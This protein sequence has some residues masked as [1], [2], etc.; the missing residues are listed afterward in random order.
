MI[1][2]ELSDFS[3]ASRIFDNVTEL[4]LIS[5]KDT[6][7]GHNSVTIARGHNINIIINSWER[8]TK[9]MAD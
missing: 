3:D 8:R 5:D 9:V 2:I 1:L 7:I 4:G 6:N